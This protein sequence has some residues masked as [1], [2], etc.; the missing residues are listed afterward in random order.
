MHNNSSADNLPSSR[1]NALFN[2]NLRYEPSSFLLHR[3]A[4]R[5][6]HRRCSRSQLPLSFA[7][8]CLASW[9][10]FMRYFRDSS[11]LVGPAGS[12]VPRKAWPLL[13]RRGRWGAAAH[14]ATTGPHKAAMGA[15]PALT[16]P[17]PGRGPLRRRAFPLLW[18][19]T[20]CS[21]P[22]LSYS[23]VRGKP[24]QTPSRHFLCLLRGVPRG[25]CSSH[26]LLTEEPQPGQHPAKAAQR[27]P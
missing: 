6:F 17:A 9:Q 1:P 18:I 26:H 23:T 20:A 14:K 3:L 2:T 8:Y 15:L 19:T 11:L 25:T 13:H 27:P 5:R 12:T 16:P 22:D 21:L 7:H 24:Q 10:P 4:L